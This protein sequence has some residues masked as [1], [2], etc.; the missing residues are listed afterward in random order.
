MYWNELF[1]PKKDTNVIL[2]K[3]S[4]KRVVRQKRR[5]QYQEVIG[6]GFFSPSLLLLYSLYVTHK[7]KGKESQKYVECCPGN[8][9]A[10]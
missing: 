3:G 6:S 4:K 5:G 2:L 9:G 8:D 1:K 10:M 7:T